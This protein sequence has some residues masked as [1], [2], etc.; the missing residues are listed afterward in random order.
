MHG[1]LIM[2]SEKTELFDLILTDGDM[3]IRPTSADDE[4]LLLQ[5]LYDPEIHRWW[6]GKPKSREIVTGLLHVSHDDDG[7]TLWPFIILQ[8]DHPIGF[9]QVWREAG[10]D[11]GLDMFL[12]PEF[13]SRG[14]GARAAH[15]LASHLRDAGW[16]RITADPAIGNEPAIRMWQKAGFEKTGEVIDIGDGPSELMAFRGEPGSSS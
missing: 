13:R 1:A 9:I 14:L 3:I 15:M 6:G 11:A 8:D 16:P 4:A 5:W 10:G 12:T 2:S 7:S